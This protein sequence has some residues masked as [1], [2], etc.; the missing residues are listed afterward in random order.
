MGF[1]SHRP[2]NSNTVLRVLYQDMAII[3]IAEEV[4]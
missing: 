3:L 2:F 4:I 1:L